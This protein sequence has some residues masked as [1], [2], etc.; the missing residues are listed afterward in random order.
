M[1]SKAKTN[2]PKDVSMITPLP[3]SRPAGLDEGNGVIIETS[4]G[5]FVF[6]FEDI[7]SARIDPSEILQGQPR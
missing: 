3:S 2:R 6:A 4:F 7:E 5:R 1:S